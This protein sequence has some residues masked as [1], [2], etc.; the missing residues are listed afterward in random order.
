LSPDRSTLEALD[1]DTP[2]GAADIAGGLFRGDV[3]AGQRAAVNLGE[4]TGGWH[5]DNMSDEV[6]KQK[7]QRIVCC[8]TRGRQF[9]ASA[10]GSR[11]KGWEVANG[12]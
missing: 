8:G 10:S 2:L 7:N 4:R 9:H 1:E 3:T 12:N 6:D 11:L 5:L